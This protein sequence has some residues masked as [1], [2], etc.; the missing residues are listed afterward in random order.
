MFLCGGRFVQG[1]PQFVEFTSVPKN[2][3]GAPG[4]KI[5]ADRQCVLQR[6]L[7]AAL[8]G[9]I[10]AEWSNAESYLALIYHALCCGPTPDRL[11][12]TSTSWVVLE[13]FDMIPAFKQRQ[14]MILR[15]AKLRGLFDEATLDEFKRLLKKVQ[16]AMEKRIKMAHGRWGLDERYSDALIWLRGWGQ[17]AGALIYEE[18]DFRTSLDA[19]T[20]ASGDLSSF[21]SARMM[22]AIR[23]AAEAAST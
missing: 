5:I 22:P 7:C 19:I 12:T 1:S 2:W 8:I 16:D 9:A 23:A 10:V 11:K 17:I 21:F 20:A 15:A 6:P 14:Q 3:T 4:A 13:T 18:A